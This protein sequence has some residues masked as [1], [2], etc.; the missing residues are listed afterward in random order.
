MNEP[1]RLPPSAS[2]VAEPT[3]P[4]VEPSFFQLPQ[5]T[6]PDRRRAREATLE[7]EREVYPLVRDPVDD[8]LPQLPGRVATLPK[9]QDFPV[10]RKAVLGTS[11]LKM[12]LNKWMSFG[13][14]NAKNAKNYR[15]YYRMMRGP[16]DV[17]TRW[18][19]D[20]EFARQ[21]VAGVNP[22]A[23]RGERGELSGDLLDATRAVL[24]DLEE[25]PTL[26]DLRRESRLFL[27][28]YPE[29]LEPE[30][31]RLAKLRHPEAQV[32]R[33]TCAFAVDDLGRL[34]PL[35][36]R[37]QPAEGP[38]AIATATGDATRWL[39]ARTH[40]QAA[41]ALLHEGYYHL[42]ETHLVNEAVAVSMYRNL[43]PEHPVRQLLEPHYE[44]NL[45]INN[46]ARGHLLSP[47]GPIDVAMGAGVDG[48]FAATRARYRNWNF[49]E[50]TL[51]ADLRRRDVDAIV[52]FPYRDDALRVRDAV[53][54]FVG[55]VLSPWYRSDRD[56][57]ED[58]ELGAWLAEA[59]A[60]D[61]GGVPGFPTLRAHGRAT[62]A[63]EIPEYIGNFQELQSLVTE[64]IFRAGPQHAAVNNGQYDS[65]GFIPNAPGTFTTALPER[66]EL[67]E[68]QFWAGLPG[69]KV[70]ASQL[71]MVWV[72]SMKTT[73]SL[74][75]TGDAPAFR[76]EV[77]HHAAEAVAAFRR[78][79]HNLSADIEERNARRDVPYIYLDPRNISRST[80]I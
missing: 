64:L 12:K 14:S 54:R 76:P 19:G 66:G 9:E 26:E 29:L 56:V 52:D 15:R 80:D 75:G 70:S 1:D 30:V 35:A 62:P 63:K 22:M 68:E 3:R 2:Q 10:A 28:D 47:N 44:G 40:A 39:V 53:H 32:T 60:D 50:R 71:G 58:N 13:V 21:R 55:A 6:S 65:Y 20:H 73:R 34:V 11:K 78:R 43:Y 4:D 59:G 38:A 46:T 79:L 77:S 41:D 25:M 45:A 23:I 61:G 5:H 67:R 72:L 36:I 33:P 74:I 27:T 18:R 48:T 69:R 8:E 7:L 17:I 42:L 51:H 16:E 24:A 57:L 31:Q 49:R 37:V